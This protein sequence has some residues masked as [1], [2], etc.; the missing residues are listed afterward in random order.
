MKEGND[1]E[2]TFSRNFRGW[3]C[4]AVVVL[5]PWLFFIGTVFYKLS[6]NN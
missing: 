1:L 5:F 2:I 4:L 6:L 3:F